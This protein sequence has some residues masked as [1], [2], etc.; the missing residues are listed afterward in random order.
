MNLLELFLKGGLVMWPILLCSFVA[1]AVIIEKYVVLARA[2]VDNKQ[3]LMKVRSALSHDD[4]KGAVD[5]CASVNAPIGAILKRGVL[6]FHKGNTAIKEGIESAAKEEIF[7]LE[8]RIGLL[9]NVSAISPMLG[10]LGTVIGMVIAFQT[11]ETLGGNADATTLS[12]GI[13][14]GLLCSAFGLIVGIPSLFFYNLFVSNITRLVHNLEVTS[15]EF[16]RMLNQQDG[17]A[18]DMPSIQPKKSKPSRT[19]FADDDDIF[20]PKGE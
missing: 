4:I 7:M 8:K 15:E 9:A 1:V 14:H 10:F 3:L 12:A 18:Q 5:A 17:A 20:E 2:N 6:N 19:V 13:W 11:I 16:F